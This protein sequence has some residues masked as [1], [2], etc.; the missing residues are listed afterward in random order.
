M[1][2]KDTKASLITEFWSYHS[3]FLLSS[4][5][6]KENS[7]LTLYANG[8]DYSLEQSV[9]CFLGVFFVEMWMMRIL[10]NLNIF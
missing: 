10:K 3:D 4:Q 8:T 1:E 7:S 9:F 2:P 5:L 6:A